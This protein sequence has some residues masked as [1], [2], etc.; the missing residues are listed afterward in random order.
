MTPRSCRNGLPLLLLSLLRPL[1]VL[2]AARLRRTNLA[3]LRDVIVLPGP[4]RHLAILLAPGHLAVLL[5]ICRSD[6]SL[7][8]W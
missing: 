3:L 5:A 8:T 4:R 2:L 6:L 1:A 7:L